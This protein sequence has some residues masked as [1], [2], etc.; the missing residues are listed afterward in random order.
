MPWHI[1]GSWRPVLFPPLGALG[2]NTGRQPLSAGPSCQ[3]PL[4][5]FKSLISRLLMQNACLLLL[6]LPTPRVPHANNTAPFHELDRNA[7]FQVLPQQLQLESCRSQDATTDAAAAYRGPEGSLSRCLP[8]FPD[9]D[10]RAM[11]VHRL[12]QPLQES[13]NNPCGASVGHQ[14]QQLG[15]DDS[16]LGP[17]TAHQTLQR[18]PKAHKTE[19]LRYF[20]ETV[21]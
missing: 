4:L 6:P 21:P 14:C 12:F 5:P 7:D 20:Q 3:P 11:E 8:G 10:R 15:T 19:K 1:Y 18:F 13:M 16:S 17:T 2:S 9:E